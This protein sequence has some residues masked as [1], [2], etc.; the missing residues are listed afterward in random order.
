MNIN[1]NTTNTELEKLGKKLEKSLSLLVTGK[2][3]F[4]KQ[5]QEML[6][7]M[8][9]K[10]GI[11]LQVDW[12]DKTVYADGY[13]QWNCSIEGTTNENQKGKIEVIR[14]RKKREQQFEDTYYP[15]LISSEIENRVHKALD[16]YFDEYKAYVRPDNTYVAN[17]FNSINQIEEYFKEKPAECTCYHVTIHLP[18][19]A[20]NNYDKTEKKLSEILKSADID[21]C[22]YIIYWTDKEIYNNITSENSIN[23]NTMKKNGKKIYNKRIRNTIYE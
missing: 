8:Y 18:D 21:N 3:N 4:E 1:N 17:K 14:W 15:I 19:H 9:K 7:H 13:N 12:S 22:Y 23:I 5:Q 16:K 20:N 11:R 6:E 10:Y 2:K